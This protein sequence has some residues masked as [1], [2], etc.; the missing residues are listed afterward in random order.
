[1]C[2]YKLKIFTYI[3]RNYFVILVEDN[4]DRK[5]DTC[6]INLAPFNNIYCLTIAM[7]M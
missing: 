1:M 2:C 4:T 7:L 3:S 6:K 5:K